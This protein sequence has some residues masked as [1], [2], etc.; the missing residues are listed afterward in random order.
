MKGDA[1]LKQEIPKHAQDL[2]EDLMFHKIPVY[3]RYRACWEEGC[4]GGREAE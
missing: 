2:I 1:E 3:P 4:F